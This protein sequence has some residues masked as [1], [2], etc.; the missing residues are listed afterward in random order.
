ML[1]PIKCM[2]H[3]KTI[4]MQKLVY[5]VASSVDGFIS[6][7]N[8]DV[9]GFL[10]TGKGVEKYLQD[11]KDF[12]TVIMGRNTYG[13]GFK[14]GA[15]PG[16]PSPAYPDMQ[17]Y[18]VSKNL[19]F[20]NQSPQVHVLPPD[21]NEIT[22]VIQSSA[23]PVYLCGGGKL[24]GWLLK[25]QL[26]DELKIKLN[27]VIIGSGIKLFE[28]VASNYRLELLDSIT[29]DNGLVVLNYQVKY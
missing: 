26:I 13:F 7:E 10:F 19:T 21:L 5:Y 18:I 23:T 24:A 12:E 27:P 22:K 28:D 6:G 16:Q 15:T 4:L 2:F 1:S 8:D 17:H 11:L 9:S 14:F 3:Q 20:E 29:Y 25:N